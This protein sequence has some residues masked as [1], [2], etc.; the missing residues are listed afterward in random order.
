[1]EKCKLPTQ[2]VRHKITNSTKLDRRRV[3]KGKSTN[4]LYKEIAMLQKIGLA[5]GGGA[6]RG[7]AHIGVLK[8]LERERIPI[9]LIAGTSMGSLVGAYY[10]CGVRPSAL[11]D[12][13]I[14]TKR[15]HIT[16][17]GFSKKGLLSTRKISKILDRD[18]GGR[19]FQDLKIPLSVVTMDLLT[20]E[21]VVINTGSV[22]EAV[23]TSISIPGVFPPRKVNGR[24]LVDGGSINQVPVSVVRNMGADFVI[25]VDVGFL[26]EKRDKYNNAV[27]IAIQAIDIMAKKL[28][29]WEEREADVIIKPDVESESITAYHKASFFIEAGTK[30]TEEVLPKIRARN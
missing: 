26:A 29:A 10:A 21:E 25:A 6:A 2:A 19:T 20:G 8:I 5:L 12:M 7:Y 30:A 28:M 17:I 11:E 27:Q 1:M 23:L 3:E 13:A 14:A 9:D 24:L 18:I 4:I 22:K 15:R 16:S